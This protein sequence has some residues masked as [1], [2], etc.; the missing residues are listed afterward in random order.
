VRS[1]RIAL[2]IALAAPIF[3][4]GNEARSLA[5]VYAAFAIGWLALCWNDARA[6]LLYACGPLL[7]PLGALAL[8]PLAVQ[9]ARGSVRRAAQGAVAIAAAAVVAGVSGRAVPFSG[10]R[11]ESLGIGPLASVARVAERL[12]AALV[13]EPR[14]L[15]AATVVATAAALLP[16]ARR[17]SP[18]GVAMVGGTLV[19][20]AIAAGSGLAS[21]P[22]LVTVWGV[23]A[24]LALRTGR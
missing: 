9:P 17:R 10:Q 15:L 18:Y 14:L 23:S 5:L 3:P 21:V 22:L 11:S 6:G 2:T 12:Q 4:L 16:W 24:A 1:P 19:I 13:S 7:A 8:V 20:A